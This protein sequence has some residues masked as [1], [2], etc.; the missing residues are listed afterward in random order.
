MLI[1]VFPF[2]FI[3]CILFH[4]KFGKPSIS[5]EIPHYQNCHKIEH[6]EHISW[7]DSNKHCLLVSTEAIRSEHPICHSWSDDDDWE[8]VD[9]DEDGKLPQ[10]LNTV[11]IIGANHC[12]YGRVQDSR[13]LV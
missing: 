5:L 4:L 9:D 1:C 3:Y 13:E 11:L 2:N 6:N 12:D 10:H 7:C 8:D